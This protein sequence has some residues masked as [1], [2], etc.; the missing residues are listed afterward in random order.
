MD[1]INTG[2]T[3]NLGSA[4][5]LAVAAKLNAEFV[6]KVVNERVGKL[7]SEAVDSALRSYSPTGKLIEQAVSDAL[8][9]DRLDLPSYGLMVAAILKEQIESRVSE[10]VAGRLAKDM[11]ELLS[12]APKEIK[13]SQI[14]ADM[15][16]RHSDEGGYGPVI[17]VIVERT[18]W[19]STWVYL[20]DNAHREGRGA[21]RECSHQMLVA[22]DGTIG[23]LSIHG[24]DVKDTKHLGSSYGLSQ[25]L[26]A[27]L[28]CGTVITIDEDDVVISVGDY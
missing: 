20:D 8:R 26:R 1:H 14:A 17:T 4:I 19:G 21:H 24:R 11:E 25:K 16:K 13:L 23:S 10:L 18:E 22:S 15:L 7:V 12:L 3:P 27:Y 5:S 28:A 2:D 6:E 9:V